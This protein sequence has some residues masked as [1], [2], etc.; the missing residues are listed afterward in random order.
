MIR[1]MVKQSSI[2]C[3]CALMFGCGG[4]QE[5]VGTTVI[6]DAAELVSFPAEASLQ[7]IQH[8]ALAP[9]GEVWALQRTGDPHLF[10]FSAEGELLSSFAVTGR[11]RNQLSNPLWLMPTDDVRQ[12]MQVW[13]AGNR[14]VVM[15]GQNGAVADLFVVERSNGNVFAGIE[16][17]SY[18][19][20]LKMERFGAGYLL[21]DHPDDLAT[22]G[23]Y[24]HSELLQLDAAGRRVGRL[25]DFD[26]E[27]SSGVASLGRYADLL[28]PIPLWTTCPAGELVLLD[29]FSNQLRFYG[30]DGSI[31][32]T[33][34]VPTVRRPI[35]EDD[36][37]AY[38]QREFELRWQE[39]RPGQPVDSAVIERSIEDFLLHY[40]N[41]MSELGPPAVQIIC[42]QDRQVWLQEF[43]TADN[44]IGYGTRWLVHSPGQ[45]E[46]LRVK[47]PSGFQPWEIA[48][49]RAFGVL[50]GVEGG[51]VVAHVT[52][53]PQA[54]TAGTAQQ[55]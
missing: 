33:D 5:D 52:L 17:H 31:L 49:E 46:P 47:F 27:F 6:I 11:A 24:L 45:V 29:P 51:S 38:L 40:W 1:N 23:D 8:V 32:A 43:S 20:P 41:R 21:L 25:L 39:Q 12:P 53:P 3:A 14:R 26:Q 48:G 54:R 13:D 35:T 2:V 55:D 10:R 9:S 18:G 4:G 30:S 7:Q 15:Y 37:Q 36:H 50:T 16:N 22:T 42:A 19:Q 34:S 44:A 28:V